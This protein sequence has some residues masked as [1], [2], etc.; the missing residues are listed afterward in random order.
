MQNI[1]DVF[2]LRA[3]MGGRGGHRLLPPDGIMMSVCKPGK[4]DRQP[5]LSIAVGKEVMSACRWVI[6][7]RVTIDMECSKSE[8]TLRRVLPS[9]RSVVSWSLTMR[10]GG[11]NAPK[12]VTEAATVKLQSTPLMISAFGM[13]D[14]TAPY[15]P[16]VVVTGAQ[17]VT[18]S[19][20]KP[21]TVRGHV[22]G[23]K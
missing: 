17:G 13:E 6:G 23:T 19:M 11:K 9:D 7:D 12:G 20:R 15:V 8:L 16:E 3:N 21:W 10:A 14:A 18:F 5:A 22:G 4:G 1:G 2:K